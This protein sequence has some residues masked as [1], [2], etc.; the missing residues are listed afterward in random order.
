MTLSNV[1]YIKS[2]VKKQI[3]YNISCNE[4]LSSEKY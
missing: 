4:S 2:T 3:S 1:K